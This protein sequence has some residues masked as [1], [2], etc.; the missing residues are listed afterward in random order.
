[1]AR[2]FP[3][4]AFS[5]IIGSGLAHANEP[6]RP[7]LSVV[8]FSGTRTVLSPEDAAELAEDLAAR[9]VETGRFRVMP[10]EWLAGSWASD[11]PVPFAAVRDAAV[12]AGVKYL[13]SAT[14]VPLPSAR[15]RGGPPMPE[16]PAVVA[17]G[18]VLALRGVRRAP[19]RC[20]PA[21]AIRSYVS[22]EVT[23]VAAE[24][25][26]V[27]RTSAARVPWDERPAGAFGSCGIRPPSL[28]GPKPSKP[29]LDL[30]KRVNADVAGT[31]T[32][33]GPAPRI[34]SR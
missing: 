33:P 29:S 21:P 16:P 31:L 25:G 15:L 18:A 27:V 22:V 10:R 34:S 7:T 30:F 23:V 2:L 5:L 3:V 6:D 13:V 1:M 20:L 8:A 11:E 26:A 28:R 17:A 12:Q 19:V 24:S 14:I 9:L 4:L 32:V